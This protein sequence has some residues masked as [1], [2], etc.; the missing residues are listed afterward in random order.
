M[1]TT[2]GRALLAGGSFGN[3]EDVIE[4]A[5]HFVADP[6]VVGR[7]VVV[8]PKLKVEQAA[9][10]QW[11]LVEGKGT[12]GE[13]KAIWEVYAHDFEDTEIFT[14]RIVGIMNRAVEIKGW[15]GWLTDMFAALKY[16]LGWSP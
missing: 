8:G 13:E 15:S 1:L 4:A 12:T 9:D 5:T 16:G 10:G 7:A 14:R 2:A 3:V 11:R 6:R